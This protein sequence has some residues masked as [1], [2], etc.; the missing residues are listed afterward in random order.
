MS[1]LIIRETFLI[2]SEQ[3]FNGFEL[4]KGLP[5]KDFTPQTLGCSYLSCLSFLDDI[6]INRRCIGM[7]TL[8]IN[9]VEKNES[10]TEIESTSVFTG[11]GGGAKSEFCK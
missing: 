3:S 10:E 7:H 2:G 11:G 9:T 8:L 5:G 1:Q 4:A 6:N